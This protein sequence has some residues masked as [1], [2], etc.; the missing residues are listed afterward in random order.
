[1]PTIKKKDRSHQVLIRRQ[2]AA[3]P[4]R[5]EKC[6]NLVIFAPLCDDIRDQW[7]QVKAVRAL[8]TERDIIG[9]FK[10]SCSSW[11]YNPRKL[12]SKKVATR[13]TTMRLAALKTEILPE[14]KRVVEIESFFGTANVGPFYATLHTPLFGE[15]WTD[16]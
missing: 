10:A 13:A 4:I 3:A 12:Q 8:L 5:C 7:C 16:C 14:M 6:N 15:K 9:N 2:K 11:L 1:M